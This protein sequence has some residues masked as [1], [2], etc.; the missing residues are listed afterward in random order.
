MN[1]M[2]S[3]V[4]I[5]INPTIY[6]K[7]PETSDLGRKILASSIDLIEQIGFE[8][9]TFRKLSQAIQSPEASMYRYFESKHKLLLYL[10]SWYWGWMEYKLLFGLANIESAEARLKIAIGI[11]TQSDE[12]SGVFPH[13]DTGKLHRIVI[14]DSSKTYLT[15]V[16]DRE[17]EDGVFSGYKQIVAHVSRI[18]QEI[19]P[20]YKYPHMLISDV[21]EG[22][23]HQRFFA[24]HLPRLTDKYSDEDA[25]TN[26]YTDMVF[27]TIKR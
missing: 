5:Q 25:V 14:S 11:L 21:I 23:H 17:N 19:N 13:I 18:V 26:F 1:G 9:F 4:V 3:N 10:T 8:A 15:K 7:S 2:L 24:E 27:K 16:V 22:A 12:S 6:L 20:E